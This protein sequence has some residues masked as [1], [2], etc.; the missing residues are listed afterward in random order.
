MAKVGGEALVKLLDS[1]PESDTNELATI[2]AAIR[3]AGPS[4]VS[5]SRVVRAAIRIFKQR[6]S[7]LVF[8][9]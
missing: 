4:V 6:M 7:E 3:N 2:F 5:R 1:T 8:F 9:F